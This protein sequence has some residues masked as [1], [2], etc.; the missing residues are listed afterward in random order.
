MSLE[1]DEAIAL[2]KELLKEL[3]KRKSELEDMKDRPD[4]DPVARGDW[5]ADIERAQSGLQDEIAHL[6]TQIDTRE[7]A[8]I[9]VPAVSNE[10][11]AKMRAALQAVS[12]AIA[13]TQDIQALL[14]VAGDIADEARKGSDA[15]G[16]A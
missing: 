12:D 7:R 5:V 2:L 14:K 11:E 9:E 1:N 15:A 10:D 8:Q 6:T 3:R 4:L 13:E 16:P